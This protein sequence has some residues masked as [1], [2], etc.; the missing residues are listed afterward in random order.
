MKN[1]VLLI[2]ILTLVSCNNEIYFEKAYYEKI[3]GIKFPEKY[4]VIETYDNGEFVTTTSFKIDSA[5][6]KRFSEKNRFDTV[7]DPFYLFFIGEKS[8]KKQKP[9]LKNKDELLYISGYSKTNTW[10]YII[11]FKKEML[12]AEIQYPDWGGTS[13]SE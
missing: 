7:R 5:V 6:L 4:R 1:L 12:W 9:D 13:P 3:S 11:D 2:L 8:L 10:L